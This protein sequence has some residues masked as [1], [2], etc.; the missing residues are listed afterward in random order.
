MIGRGRVVPPGESVTADSPG[1][2]A[3]IVDRAARR[4]EI[5]ELACAVSERLVGDLIAR[6]RAAFAGLVDAALGSL[7]RAPKVLLWAHPGDAPALRAR[8]AELDAVEIHDDPDR[9]P[10][11]V[12]ACADGIGTLVVDLPSAVAALRAA[13]LDE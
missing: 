10:H 3:L 2:A 11:T 9:S 1:L 8:F 4:R 13:L 12:L 5:V 6:D 7:A